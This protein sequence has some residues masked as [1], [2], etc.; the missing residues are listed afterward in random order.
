MRRIEPVVTVCA[1][2]RKEASSALAESVCHSSPKTLRAPYVGGGDAC[3]AIT[4]GIPLVASPLKID[5]TYTLPAIAHRN[6]CGLEC[7]MTLCFAR[8][9]AEKE[10]CGPIT[11]ESDRVAPR[12]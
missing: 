7:M 3:A 6:D 8:P 9:E 10:Y 5:R 12:T 4:F 11:H 2:A 1:E